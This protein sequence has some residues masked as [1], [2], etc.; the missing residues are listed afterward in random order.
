MANRKL[1]TNGRL[2]VYAD[3]NF[4]QQFYVAGGRKAW[5]RLIS[6]GER[7]IVTSVILEEMEKSNF[8]KEFEIWMKKNRSQMEPSKITFKQLNDADPD[9]QTPYTRAGAGDG[10]GDASIR[11]SV[12]NMLEKHPDRQVQLVSGDQSLVNYFRQESMRPGN[13][14]LLPHRGIFGFLRTELFEGRIKNEIYDAYTSRIRANFKVLDSIS[15]DF[16]DQGETA[17]QLKASSPEWQTGDYPDPRNEDPEFAKENRSR[18]EAE[19]E[20]RRLSDAER[21]T[22]GKSSGSPDGSLNLLGRT[23]ARKV[24]RGLGVV[25]DVAEFVL[26]VEEAANLIQQDN[27]PEAERVLGSFIGGLGGSAVGAAAAGLTAGAVLSMTG[28]GSFVGVPVMVVSVLVGGFLGDVA[29]RE[30]AG[31]LVE[32]IQL[33]QA[34]GESLL[35]D[36]IIELFKGYSEKNGMDVEGLNIPSADTDDRAMSID[37]PDGRDAQV[38]IERSWDIVQ[39]SADREAAQKSFDTGL[40]QA[41][42]ELMPEGVKQAMEM[43]TLKREV[44]A[45]A[46][47]F[48]AAS[49]AAGEN[50]G[51]I[52]NGAV[53]GTNNEQ[54][55]VVVPTPRP[56]PQLTPVRQG[57]LK[58]MADDERLVLAAEFVAHKGRTET[59]AA[60][61]SMIERMEVQRKMAQDLADLKAGKLSSVWKEAGY[62]KAVR[63]VLGEE[64]YQSF[65][66][67]RLEA[68]LLSNAT[69]G[70]HLMQNA[71]LQGIADGTAEIK[72]P[73]EKLAELMTP[74]VLAAAAARATDILQM[75][76]A[77]PSDAV[78]LSADLAKRKAQFDASFD[79]GA[80]VDGE[81]MAAFLFYLDAAQREIGTAEA[82]IEPIPQSWAKQVAARFETPLASGAATPDRRSRETEIKQ[83]YAELQQS[84]GPRTDDVIAYS[85]GRFASDAKPPERQGFAR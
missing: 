31:F 15:P 23:N 21:G 81:E 28:A 19:K 67:E 50:A 44:T 26:V 42:L 40:S 22:G 57:V 51:A 52:E 71:D 14:I 9:R 10:A 24:L 62:P 13:N 47:E 58:G 32:E 2:Y 49:G 7:L 79:T 48:A 17:Q 85:L 82:N 33:R 29:G 39:Q 46:A 41:D 80:A 53:N 27:L 12:K 72:A 76:R 65:V 78:L 60:E 3:T 34:K 63:D 45:A 11:L 68:G 8:G 1:A 20:K 54:E 55:P 35:L 36:D 25:G 6:R 83:H 61:A 37:I 77:K 74:K 5:D 84:F 30:F 73:H 43:Q 38:L 59:D 69:A 56:R 64:A 18:V 70:L 16:R 4:L 66:D 75:R